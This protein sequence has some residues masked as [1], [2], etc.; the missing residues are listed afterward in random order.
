[1]HLNKLY[2]LYNKK[3]FCENIYSIIYI[4]KNIYINIYKYKYI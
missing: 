4:I 2:F 1:M 3:L